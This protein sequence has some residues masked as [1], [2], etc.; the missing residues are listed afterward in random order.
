MLDVED[1]VDNGVPDP[2]LCHGHADLHLD[3][4]WIAP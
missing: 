4:S 2:I 3:A 1:F